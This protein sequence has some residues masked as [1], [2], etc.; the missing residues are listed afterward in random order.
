MNRFAVCI[1]YMILRAIQQSP[2]AN[3]AGR[4]TGIHVSKTRISPQVAFHPCD[5]LRRIVWL[6]HIIICTDRQSQYLV[7]LFTF[8]TKH[9]NRNILPFSDLHNRRKSIHLRHHNVD[10]NK[11]NLFFREYLQRLHSIIRPDRMK[12]LLLQQNCNCPDNFPVI[13]HYK[14]PFVFHRVFSPFWPAFILT[15]IPYKSVR[16]NLTDFL[17]TVWPDISIS[18]ACHFLILRFFAF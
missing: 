7:R 11:L 13:V 3:L 1:Q 12:S 10:Q 6:C 4:R 14:Y 2:I 18:R 15:E 8:R 5:Q 16:E 17:K 9:D